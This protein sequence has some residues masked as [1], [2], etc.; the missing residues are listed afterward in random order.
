MNITQNIN[1]MKN[2]LERSQSALKILFYIEKP[3]HHIEGNIIAIGIQFQLVGDE[4]NTFKY[5]QH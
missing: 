4:L 1:L 3:Q 2:F 5:S